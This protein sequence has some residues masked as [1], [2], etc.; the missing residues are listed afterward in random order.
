MKRFLWTIAPLLFL[1][2]LF[3]DRAVSE[4][5][6]KSVTFD[7]CGTAESH[8]PGDISSLPTP[9]PLW[10]EW[11]QPVSVPG[12]EQ[13]VRTGFISSSSHRVI[14]FGVLQLRLLDT[15]FD[16]PSLWVRRLLFPFHEHT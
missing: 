10:A 7:V 4:S 11:V 16:V 8:Q 14:R 5:V 3:A 13:R 9:E 15:V 12:S 1:T 6:Q 2:L